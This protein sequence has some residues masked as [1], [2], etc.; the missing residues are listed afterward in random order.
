MN[1]IFRLLYAYLLSLRERLN[2]GNLDSRLS[3]RVRWYPV[4]AEHA[5]SSGVIKPDE[6]LA[7]IEESRTK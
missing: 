2:A 7:S 4:I 3:L 6:V 5:M 1:L